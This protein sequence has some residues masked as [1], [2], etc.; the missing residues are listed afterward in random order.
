VTISTTSTAPHASVGSN[1]GPILPILLAL[2][3]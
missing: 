1:I 3:V 2:A